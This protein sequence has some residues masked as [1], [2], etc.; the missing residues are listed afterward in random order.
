[1]DWIR[2]IP[3]RSLTRVNARNISLRR[4]IF[5]LQV[6]E[7]ALFVDGVARPSSHHGF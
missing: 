3:D 5:N 6:A 7:T 1:M 4:K 2:L